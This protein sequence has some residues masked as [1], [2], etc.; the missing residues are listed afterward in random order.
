MDF[1]LLLTVLAKYSKIHSFPEECL[2]DKK[3]F[4]STKMQSEL[5]TDPLFH[6]SHFSSFNSTLNMTRCDLSD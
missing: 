2:V 5:L 3:I 6:D 1:K 4:L